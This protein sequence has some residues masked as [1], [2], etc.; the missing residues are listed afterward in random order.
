MIWHWH[1]NRHVGQR[2]ELEDPHMSPDNHSH[3]ICDKE[4][5]S[6]HWRKNLKTN[7]AVK[8]GCLPAEK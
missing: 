7:C 6:I 5:K 8:T 2:T 4:A 1:K 3:L